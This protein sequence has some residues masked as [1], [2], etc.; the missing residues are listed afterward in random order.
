MNDFIQVSGKSVLMLRAGLSGIFIVAGC[1]HL[2]NPA[3]VEKRI[4]E[5]PY[6]SLAD[7]FGDPYLLG[8]LSGLAL[9]VFG[10]TFLLGIYTKWSALVLLAVLVP[11]TATIQ[12]GHGVLYGPLWKNIALLAGL[13]FFI[14][15]NP[16]NHSI[17]N[18]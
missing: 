8:V 16:K 3:Q 14:R 10:L 4:Q 13:L 15:S 1:S 17:Y 18:K 9:L 12:L 11:I 7:F 2:I 5:A 6:G